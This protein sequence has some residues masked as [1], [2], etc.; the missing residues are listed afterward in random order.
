[1]PTTIAL[2]S[3][4]ILVAPGS[5]DSVGDVARDVARAHRYVIVS[6]ANVEPLYAPRVA[7]SFGGERVDILRVPAGEEHK[8][9]ESWARLT[10]EM[11]AAGC[12][13][14]T[15][16]IALGGGVVGDLAGFVAATYMRG[17]PYLQVPT[18]LLAMIDSS[19]G[20]K[21]R[22]GTA[23]RKKLAGAVHQPVAVVVDPQVLS[24]LPHAQRRA[25][26][27]EAIKHGV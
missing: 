26:M 23:A 6:D 7:A 25:A 16:L 21:T 19:I 14:D 9:R 8:T 24:T 4:R 5:L 3:Y 2:P 11:L 10:D 15:T 12:G 22:G 17:I 1:M 18:T 27:A 20:G 13:R